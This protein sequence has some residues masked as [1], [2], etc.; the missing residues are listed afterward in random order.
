M[1]ITA[2]EMPHDK[3]KTVKAPGWHSFGHVS[4]DGSPF[5]AVLNLIAVVRHSTKAAQVDDKGMVGRIL[6]FGRRNLG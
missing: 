2:P 3:N 5:S 6:G 4:L 1:S